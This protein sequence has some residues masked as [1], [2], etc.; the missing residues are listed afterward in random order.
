[1][2]VRA[3]AALGV[4]LASDGNVS[5]RT[6]RVGLPPSPLVTVASTASAARSSV[7]HRRARGV[8]RPT[9]TGR[10][11]RR[12]AAGTA[13]GPRP[14]PRPAMPIA[15]V[16]S[17][18]RGGG[19]ASAGAPSGS[20]VPAPVD[21]RAIACPTS[22][23]VSGPA[24]SPLGAASRSTRTAPASATPSAVGGQVGC[25]SGPSASA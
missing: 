16:G 12:L 14:A 3:I 2:P 10:T 15:T 5:C 23:A 19:G 17:A 7:R 9:P 22:R 18:S 8:G 21:A 6:V 11:C 4:P 24:S 1:M 13:H 25:T 20:T